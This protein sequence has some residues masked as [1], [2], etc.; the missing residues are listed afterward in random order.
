MEFSLKLK[1]EQVVITGV[2]DVKRTYVL[3]ELTGQQ[4]DAYLNNMGGRM[5]FND[6]GK[7]QGLSNYEGL[8]SGLLK[9]C[10]Y[11]DDGKLV[12]EK[13][14]QAWPSQVLSALFE[15]AQEMSALNKGEEKKAECPND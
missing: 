7:T 9:L 12:P 4:R 14:L 10:V 15:K 5:K 3:K 2:D 1:E 13:E 6:E 11:S 8:Q